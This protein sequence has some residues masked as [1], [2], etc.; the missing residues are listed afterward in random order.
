MMAL[1]S[2]IILVAP[3]V[4]PL[5]GT[6]LTA[7]FGWRTVFWFL[8]FAGLAG[9]A[10]VA[11]VLPETRSVESRANGHGTMTGYGLLL[12]DRTFVGAAMM[13]GSS[14]AA[15][16]TYIAASP[17]V[18][19]TAF[20]VEA[21]AYS[22]IYALGAVCAA[23]SAQFGSRLMMRFGTSSTLAGCTRIGLLCVVI[24]LAI[25]LL[26]VRSLWFLLP[27]VF[28]V[29]ASAGIVSPVGTV[30]ALHDH[31]PSA[32]TASALIGTVSYASGAVA[33]F[34]VTMLADGTERPMLL[35][36]ALCLCG[37][38]IGAQL[39]LSPASRPARPA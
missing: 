10:L 34:A 29:F 35:V 15:L 22:L 36:M 27:A 8:S 1:M 14:Q 26:D 21:M 11:F 24:S 19:R 13:I 2:L 32:G 16:F 25:A 9:L 33:A 3:L 38:N 23:V 28:I 17:F 12:R 31:A 7:L 30:L 37:A 5:G 4:A 39:A 6:A 20:G 18:L